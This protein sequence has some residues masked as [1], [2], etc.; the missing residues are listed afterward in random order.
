VIG[1][2]AGTGVDGVVFAGAMPYV[3]FDTKLKEILAA[4][5]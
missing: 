2:T 3:T 4:K 5:K 1:K